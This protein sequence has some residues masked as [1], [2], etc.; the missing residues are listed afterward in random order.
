MDW[1]LRQLE[2]LA[3]QGDAEADL[4]LAY[5][6]CRIGRHVL[7]DDQII[8]ADDRRDANQDVGCCQCGQELY[9]AQQLCQMGQHHIKRTYWTWPTWDESDPTNAP[10]IAF[11]ND[12]LEHWCVRSRIDTAK[13]NQDPNY[14]Q[15]LAAEENAGSLPRGNNPFAGP[16]GCNYRLD[17]MESCARGMHFMAHEPV[18]GVCQN[19]DCSYIEPMICVHP[20]SKCGYP[21]TNSEGTETRQCTR[22]Q[23]VMTGEEICQ[24]YGH[25]A[26]P[27]T[28]NPCIRSYCSIH[29]PGMHI[30]DALAEA[31]KKTGKLQ[32]IC[33][34]FRPTMSG[35]RRDPLRQM[36]TIAM[37]AGWNNKLRGFGVKKPRLTREDRAKRSGRFW[38]FSD[39]SRRYQVTVSWGGRGK[40]ENYIKVSGGL[41]T[42]WNGNWYPYISE[43]PFTHWRWSRPAYL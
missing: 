28:A 13:L 37:A 27:A 19:P 35:S 17:R 10:D 8:L 29:K 7:R 22:C 43:E 39:P 20:L 30:Y 40:R 11:F 42:R 38:K 26:D 14:L 24:Q 6:G 16:Y 18:G 34:E 5:A 2:R 31:H 3:A 36:N 32:V 9:S 12:Q 4:R 33:R 21:N 25:V 23:L 1:H 41:K 15:Q